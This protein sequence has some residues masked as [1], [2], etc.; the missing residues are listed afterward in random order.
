MELKG[1]LR[2]G[3]LITAPAKGSFQ[4]QLEEVLGAQAAILGAQSQT[5]ELTSQTIFLRDPSTAAECEAQLEKLYGDRKP[6]T[7][8]VAQRPCTGA[9]LALDAWGIGGPGIAIQRF[10]KNTI[11]VAYDGIRWTHCGR[12]SPS[13]PVGPI[14]PRAMEALG[15]MSEELVKAGTSFQNVVRTW[16]YLGG[17]TDSEAST[18]R[19]QELNRS[20]VDFYR[21][22][23]FF[24]S[25]LD[26]NAPRG[27][28]PASTGIGMQGDGLVMSCLALDTQR[29]D[30]LLY[31]LENP[32]QTPAYA[33]HPRYST[34]SPKFSRAIALVT[35]D[36]VTTWI[37]GTASIVDSESRHPDDIEKQTEQTI[38]NIERLI[39]EEN[40]SFHGIHGTGVELKDFAKL[41][42]Y[43]KRESDMAKCKAICER[44]FGAVP[45]VYALAEIC[46]PELL[47]EIEGVAFSR[48]LGSKLVSR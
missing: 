13:S 27:V 1:Q 39:A 44:R 33:Y 32:Q 35:N 23:H 43:L 38:D 21:N 36:Y 17:I 7:S 48:Y 19:Y 18:H 6:I 8:Y 5:M 4:A 26:P 47:V 10:G 2:A 46:R 37:S 29:H 24:R 3:M 16:F 12:V 9:A 11:S 30:L 31:P 42:V 34:Q 20:R 22:V 40:F 15:R 28:Y 14:Y 41:R 45:T 25:L